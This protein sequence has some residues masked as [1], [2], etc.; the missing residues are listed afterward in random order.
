MPTAEECERVIDKLTFNDDEVLEDFFSAVEPSKCHRSDI[1]L[2]EMRMSS[3]VH[4]SFPWVQRLIDA[5]S[6][7]YE[8]PTSD[9]YGPGWMSEDYRPSEDNLPDDW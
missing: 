9:D 3:S 7:C 1:L 5:V 4:H 6:G 8:L 2:K